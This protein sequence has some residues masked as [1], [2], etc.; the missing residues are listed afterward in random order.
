M[1]RLRSALLFLS[2]FSTISFSMIKLLTIILCILICSTPSFAAAPDRITGPIVSS[3][4]IKLSGGVPRRA[5]PQYDQGPVDPSFK[6]SYMTLLTVPPAGQQKAIDR[7][8]AQQQDP[9]SP[10]YHQWLTPEQYADRFGLSPNDVQK[11]TGWL[12]SQGFSIREV[13][14]GRNWIVF[15]GTSAQVETAFQT[16]IHN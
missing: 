15:S 2:N 5:Q 9:R 16:K 6:L 12:Q 8:L 4:L 13:A 11:I 7:L 3:Q 10:L 14:R 1:R